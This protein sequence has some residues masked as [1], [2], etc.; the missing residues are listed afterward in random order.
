MV[1]CRVDGGWCVITRNSLKAVREKVGRADV[2]M[3]WPFF[4]STF[5][6]IFWSISIGGFHCH[7][8]EYVVRWS[9]I[10]E[11]RLIMSASLCPLSVQPLLL[12]CQC[13]LCVLCALCVFCAFW[14]LCALCVLSIMCVYVCLIYMF[15]HVY[16]MCVMCVKCVMYATRLPLLTIHPS[17]VVPRLIAA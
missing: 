17:A 4:R 8:S 14:V 13:V 10:I 6:F 2:M 3:L 12:V 1:L 11:E 7:Q 9:I 5:Q 15:V 16:V